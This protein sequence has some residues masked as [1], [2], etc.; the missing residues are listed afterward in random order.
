MKIIMHACPEPLTFDQIHFKEALQ[1][2]IKHPNT[3][4]NVPVLKKQS[5][6]DETA[7]VYFKDLIKQILHSQYRIQYILK[8]RKELQQH[9]SVNTPFINAKNVRLCHQRFNTGL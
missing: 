6:D 3:M 2:L 9:H 5:D 7:E 8:K 1:K 4:I